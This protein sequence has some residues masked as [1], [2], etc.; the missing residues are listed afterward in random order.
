MFRWYYVAA[1]FFLLAST[2]ALGFIDRMVYG[3]WTNNPGDKITETLNVLVIVVSFFLFWH[4]IRRLRRPQFNRV[5][6]LAAAGLFL[7]SVMWS[8]T[9]AVTISRA[10]AYFFVVAGAIGTV[11][12]LDTNEVMNLNALIGGFSGAA[13]SIRRSTGTRIHATVSTACLA[14]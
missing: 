11:E 5:L 8:V 10:V 13:V 9:P 7:I 4:G 6:P 1:G 3:E 12:F 2:G 14:V